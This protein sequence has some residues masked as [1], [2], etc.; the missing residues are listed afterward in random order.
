MRKL[1]GR[2]VADSPACPRQ[3]KLPRARQ[4]RQTPQPGGARCRLTPRRVGGNTFPGCGCARAARQATA[5]CTSRTGRYLPVP[6]PPGCTSGTDLSRPARAPRI[7]GKSS[8]PSR[9]TP[10]LVRRRHQMADPAS[11]A[12]DRPLRAVRSKESVQSAQ[13]A[14]G[15]RPEVDASFSFVSVS[16]LLRRW[17]GEPARG[18]PPSRCSC[19]RRSCR[20]R[21]RR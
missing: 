12:S 10:C 18:F 15:R 5:A 1:V 17:V 11:G 9:V 3:P 20:W 21:N 4:H 7:G 19:R 16:T 13:T 8:S 2:A 6:P 14:W